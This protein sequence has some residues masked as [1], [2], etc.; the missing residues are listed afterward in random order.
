MNQ[1]SA[2]LGF[3]DADRFSHLRER[4]RMSRVNGLC[5][6][7]LEM[8]DRDAQA[9]MDAQHAELI[10]LGFEEVSL[11]LRA[12]HASVRNDAIFGRTSR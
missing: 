8:I 7:I 4:Q 10:T 1:F 2:H 9:D 3:A 11:A 6:Q 12:R 5:S